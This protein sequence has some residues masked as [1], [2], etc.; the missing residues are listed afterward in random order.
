VVVV[1]E[2]STAPQEA[3]GGTAK[4]RSDGIHL[5]VARDLLDGELGLV[6]RLSAWRNRV[7][8]DPRIGVAEGSESLG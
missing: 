1:L 7:Y 5:R 3:P 4:L 2:D 6:V 8:A